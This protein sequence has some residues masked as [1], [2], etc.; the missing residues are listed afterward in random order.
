MKRREFLKKSL[1]I[2]SL[3]ALCPTLLTYV[4]GPVGLIAQG[5]NFTLVVYEESK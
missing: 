4:P 3:F 5:I 1:T 2:S